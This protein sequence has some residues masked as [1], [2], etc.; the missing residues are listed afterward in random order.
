MLRNINLRGRCYLHCKKLAANGF[1]LIISNNQIQSD[2][3][4]N[5]E[6]T[7]AKC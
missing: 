3:E 4:N 5:A 2:F 1:V 6:T 7:K